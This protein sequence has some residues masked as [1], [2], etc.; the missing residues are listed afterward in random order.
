MPYGLTNA[1]ATFQQFMDELKGKFVQYL[2]AR[3]LPDRYADQIF[4]YLDDWIIISAK[5]EEHIVLLDILFNILYEA[6]LKINKEKSHFTRQSV[7]FLGF[8]LDMDGLKPYPERI[9]PILEYP[10][11]RNRKE[12]RRFNGSVNWYHR[13]LRN[14]AKVQGPLNKLASPKVPW[15]WTEECETAF[16]NVKN[17][18]KEATTLVPPRPDLPF[19]LYTDASDTGLGAILT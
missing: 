8:I 15:V 3:K 12:L 5:F 14:I 9:V 19:F 1:P 11:P 6:G 2:H 4:A 10:R 13:Y 18:L 7:E 16:N 17:A